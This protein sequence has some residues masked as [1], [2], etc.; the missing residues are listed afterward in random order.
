[1]T[2]SEDDLNH[3]LARESGILPIRITGGNQDLAAD[4][5]QALLE[6]RRRRGIHRVK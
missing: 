1:M 4:L 3:W 5:K 2:A 6:A